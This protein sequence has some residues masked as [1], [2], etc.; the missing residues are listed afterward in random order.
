[1]AS[2]HLSNYLRKYRKSLALSQEE[3]AYLLGTQSGAKVCRYERFLRQPGLRTALAFEAIF[4]RPV[5]ELFPGIYQYIEAQVRAR[6]RKLADKGSQ[7]GAPQF[8]GRKRQALAAIVG[9]KPKDKK[10][11]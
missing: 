4:Q 10:Q 1:M 6:A 2:Q 11:S 7:G 3:V 5:S 9:M 8:T